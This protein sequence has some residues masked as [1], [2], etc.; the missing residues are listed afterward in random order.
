M[1]QILVTPKA[2]LATIAA[3]AMVLSDQEQL[4]IEAAGQTLPSK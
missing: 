2:V 1:L 3:Q 4:N